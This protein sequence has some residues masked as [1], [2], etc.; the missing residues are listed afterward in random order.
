M[1]ITA[2]STIL[3]SIGALLFKIVSKD[4]SHPIKVLLKLQ[5]YIGAFL[6][7]ISAIMFVFALRFGDLSALYPVAALNYVWVSLL[8]V[9]FLKE[10]MNRYRWFGIFLIILG[11]V[12]IGVGA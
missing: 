9:A 7:G 10:K 11:V 5:F 1:G 3:G 8:S 12:A 4:I 6:Y 2:G